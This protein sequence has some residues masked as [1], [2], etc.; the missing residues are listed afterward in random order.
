[1]LTIKRQKY[2]GRTSYSRSYPCLTQMASSMEII[3]ARWQGVTSTDGGSSLRSRSNQL[4]ITLRDSL[5]KYTMRERA[6]CTVT[7]M[8]THASL[9]S[10]CMGATSKE[11]QKKRGFFL[12]CCPK[13]ALC[14]ISDLQ[15]LESKSLRSL[16]QE[17]LFSKSLKTAL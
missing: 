17:S 12:F 11:R 15:G 9:T 6:C 8:A 7:C 10:S 13:S 14:S 1:M 2:S 4:F 3:V 16:Q 5:K